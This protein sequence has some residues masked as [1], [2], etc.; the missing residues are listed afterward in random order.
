MVFHR[1]L[2]SAAMWL[3]LCEQFA[4]DATEFKSARQRYGPPQAWPKGQAEIAAPCAGVAAHPAAAALCGVPD[5]MRFWWTCAPSCCPAQSDKRLLALDA[6]LEQ[7]FSTWFDVAF[8]SCAACR[9][10][11]PRR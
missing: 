11:R 4:P 7:L 1:E 6:E 3:L 8:W 5:G 10:I 2:E 9:G